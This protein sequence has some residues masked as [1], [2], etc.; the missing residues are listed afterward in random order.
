MFYNVSNVVHDSIKFYN[1][2][3]DLKVQGFKS[4]N[5]SFNELTYNFYLPLTSKLELQ[6]VDYGNVMK[7]FADKMKV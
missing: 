4:F 7:N 6:V 5:K 1:S 2:F 3:I